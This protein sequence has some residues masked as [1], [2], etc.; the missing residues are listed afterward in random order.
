VKTAEPSEPM[1]E[2]ATTVVFVR[3]A[4]SPRQSDRPAKR[5]RAPRGP[6]RDPE[7]LTVKE[8]ADLLAVN[9]KTIHQLIAEGLPHLRVAKRVIRIDRDVLI[10]WCKAA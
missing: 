1:D 3:S 2:E 5:E 4:A 6:T 10:S 8:A 9:V 7:M